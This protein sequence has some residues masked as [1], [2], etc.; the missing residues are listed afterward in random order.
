MAAPAPRDHVSLLQ[1]A[2]EDVLNT[3]FTTITSIQR[4]A[5]APTQSNAGSAIRFDQLPVLA[6][7]IVKKVKMIYVL[8]DETDAETCIGKDIDEIRETL[9]RRSSEYEESVMGLSATC[10]QAEMWIVRI[11]DM[12]NIIARRTPWLHHATDRD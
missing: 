10:E 5:A 1:E 4:D 8:I 11:N 7:Q 6:D 9:Q 3:M 2:F 12:L